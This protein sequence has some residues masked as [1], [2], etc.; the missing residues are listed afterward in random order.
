M[1]SGLRKVA[2]GDTAKYA[3]DNKL[4]DELA[5]RTE[6]EKSLSKQ[7]GWSKEDKN[8]SAISMYD[9]STKETG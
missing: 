3:L 2:G 8:Y 9:Y 7:F 6:I 4:V 1:L 5:S